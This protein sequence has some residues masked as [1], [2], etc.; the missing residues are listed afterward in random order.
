MRVEDKLFD[1]VPNRIGKSSLKWSKYKNSDII[2]LW[3]ADMDFRSPSP[4]IQLAREISDDGNFGYGICPPTLSQTVINRLNDFYHWSVERN[5]II[6]LPGMVCG[7]NIACRSLADEAA[8]VITNTPVYPPFLS[9]PGNSGLPCTRIPMIV[10]E[11]RFT[12]DFDAL[13]NLETS[14]NDLFMLCH[15]HNPVGTNFSRKELENLSE[16]IIERELFIC[17][18]EIHCDL[19]LEESLS[20]IPFASLSDEIAD[21]TITLMAPSKTFNLAGFGCSFA[22]ISNAGLRKRF[23]KAMRGIVP[24]PPAMGFRL[25]EVAYREC[26]DWRTRLLHYL[27]SNRDF[28]FKELLLLDGLIPY[29]PESTY[30]MWIDATELKVDCPHAFFENAG[31][32]LSNGADFAGPGFLRLNLGSSFDLLELAIARMKSAISKL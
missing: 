7:L 25:A 10:T 22:I 28:V 2:P 18:D 16:Y 15:P 3:V 20:H 11:G 19:I 21:R 30:L 12:I 14:P 27:R 4:V 5:S 24:D 8:Q 23:K 17:S 31:V 29:S 32:G 13:H 1:E 9:S 26:E 6:W